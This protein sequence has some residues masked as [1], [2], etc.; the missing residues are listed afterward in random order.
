MFIP[1]IPPDSNRTKYN[2]KT[3]QLQ[4]DE[5]FRDDS[6]FAQNMRK[7]GLQLYHWQVVVYKG[8]IIKEFVYRMNGQVERLKALAELIAEYGIEDTRRFMW[9]HGG[10]GMKE[11]YDTYLAA[12]PEDVYMT[13]YEVEEVSGEFFGTSK[14]PFGLISENLKEDMPVSIQNSNWIVRMCYRTKTET[15]YTDLDLYELVGCKA[16][17]NHMLKEVL[18]Q[19]NRIL[20]DTPFEDVEW[21]KTPDP[22]N[23][24]KHQI[25][26]YKSGEGHIEIDFYERE[27]E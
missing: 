11:A 27:C 26:K 24:I 6:F 3:K 5:V 25:V 21:V 22:H 15:E 23:G 4:T 18:R 7:R 1:Y 12:H 9:L 20:K 17:Q 19:V 8:M 14:S 10:M 2:D 16:D 13:E